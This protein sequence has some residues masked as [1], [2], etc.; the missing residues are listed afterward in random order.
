MDTPNEPSFDDSLAT[1][2]AQLPPPIREFIKSGKADPIAKELT[3]KYQLHLDQG[4]VVGREIILILLGI[5]SPADFT[6]ALVQE[7]HLDA[8]TVDAIVQE[9]NQR[10]FIPLRDQMRGGIVSSI[11]SA[12]LPKP[13]V[14]P[15]EQRTRSQIPSMSTPAQE[16]TLNRLAPEQKPM[17]TMAKAAMNIPIAVPPP[18]PAEQASAT[19]Q[20][21]PVG[22]PK[23]L[24]AA[25]K[26]AG[27]PL[28]EDH[29][30]PR[31]EFKKPAPAPVAA[32]KIPM[33]TMP[34]P[35]TPVTPPVQS[36][37]PMSYSAD[38]YREPI[39]PT[40]K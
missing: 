15:T 18:K 5:D 23:P 19:R 39:D 32:P 37:P 24:A 8:S 4:A 7:A 30:E 35:S 22:A 40:E 17:A 2:V 31:I 10:I 34:K 14:Q 16:K 33:T 28:L 9:V 26:A 6:T 21:L 1:V 27:I 11:A 3:Q 29:E 13:S 25:L 12:T 20:P 36:K 38:P